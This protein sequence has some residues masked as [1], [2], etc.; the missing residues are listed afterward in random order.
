MG[1][2]HVLL[3]QTNIIDFNESDILE[4]TFFF[5]YRTKLTPIPTNCSDFLNARRISGLKI[6]KWEASN[7]RSIFML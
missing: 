4:Q 3:V 6:K 1:L 5:Y 7:L 2:R